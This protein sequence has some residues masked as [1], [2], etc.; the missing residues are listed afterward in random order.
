MYYDTHAAAASRVLNVYLHLQ[1]VWRII[2]PYYY[3]YY[4]YNAR[5]FVI[6]V[7]VRY[8]YYVRQRYYIASGRLRVGEAYGVYVSLP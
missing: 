6:I 1:C 3:Y 2:H 5:S 7:P 8:Y 4:Y